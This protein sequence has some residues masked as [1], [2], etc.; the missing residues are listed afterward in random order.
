MTCILIKMGNLDTETG[1]PGEDE[2]RDQ[3]GS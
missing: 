3:G 1:M 2:S